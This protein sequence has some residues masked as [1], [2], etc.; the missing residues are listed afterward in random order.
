[1]LKKNFP[2][3]QPAKL[4]LTV[5]SKVFMVAAFFTLSVF[6]VSAQSPRIPVPVPVSGQP[7]AALTIYQ[8]EFNYGYL[9]GKKYRER[10]D[11]AGYLSMLNHYY[12][13]WSLYPENGEFYRGRIDGLNAGWRGNITDL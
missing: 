13:F 12:Y 1:M 2:E 9:E 6:A 8:Q 5:A 10:P 7:T 11:E 3:S 4:A